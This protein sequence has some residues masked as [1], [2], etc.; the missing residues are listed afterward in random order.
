MH[1]ICCHHHHHNHHHQHHYRH[2]HHRYHHHLH[3]HQR[4]RAWHH[5]QCDS[6]PLISFNLTCPVFPVF[7]LWESERSWMWKSARCIHGRNTACCQ[8]KKMS[9]LCKSVH[10]QYNSVPQITCLQPPP[11][12]WTHA[13][14]H[15]DETF[16][17]Y[18][19]HPNSL[20]S[21]S[22]FPPLWMGMKHLIIVYLVNNSK[23][24]STETLFPLII[25]LKLGKDQ[26][27]PVPLRGSGLLTD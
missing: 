14:P 10:P 22:L 4:S 7:R 8:A 15:M 11:P 27:K 9:F 17:W 26:T 3:H 2:H 6:S 13:L 19:L 23:N 1:I 12:L 20:S 24:Q 5:L 21:F 18:L 25:W 16:H